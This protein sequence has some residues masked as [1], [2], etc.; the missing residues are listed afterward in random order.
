MSESK[1]AK[2]FLTEPRNN[3]DL[4]DYR[5][6]PTYTRE[7]GITRVVDLTNQELDA[8]I[9]NSQTELERISHTITDVRQRLGR[10]YDAIETRKLDLD[11]LAVRIRELR[12]Q[13]E[14]LQARK[15]EIE[16]QMSDKRVDLI[17]MGLMERY[18]SDLQEILGEGTP[19]ERR[20]FI[21]SF[22]DEIRVTGEEAVMTYRAPI[23]DQEITLEGER[24][25]RTV[26]YG[27]R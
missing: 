11:D 23:P 25:P 5:G 18:V 20:A 16:A 10:L 6:K 24:V 2:Y 19:A 13:E 1:Y 17:D 9:D 22:V 12:V 14:R 7:S 8:H 3:V 26:R 27:G 21:R 4:P 15:L